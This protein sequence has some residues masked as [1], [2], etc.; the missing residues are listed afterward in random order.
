MFVFGHR[1]NE[2]NFTS[3]DD[4]TKKNTTHPLYAA[5][6][7]RMVCRRCFVFCFLPPPVQRITKV[8]LAPPT[9]RPKRPRE[10][11]SCRNALSGVSAQQKQEQRQW[12]CEELRITDLANTGVPGG[13]VGYPRAYLNQF[14]EFN[15]H[16]VHILVRTSCIKRLAG[17]SRA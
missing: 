16:R 11:S 2:N 3:M 1:G 15:S 7:Y 8:W 10:L 13:S 12:S 9:I 5:A 4:S 6:V 14:R 17:S